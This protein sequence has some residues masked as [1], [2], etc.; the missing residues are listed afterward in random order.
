MAL[1]TIIESAPRSDKSSYAQVTR[2]NATDVDMRCRCPSHPHLVM[3]LQRFTI[4]PSRVQI[5]ARRRVKDGAHL[6]Q[7]RTVLR[8]PVTTKPQRGV[9]VSTPFSLRMSW[10]ESQPVRS[11]EVNRHPSGTPYGLS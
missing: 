11:S 9:H 3:G 5:I 7:K 8:L 10:L 6:G 1:Y 2:D 4:Q